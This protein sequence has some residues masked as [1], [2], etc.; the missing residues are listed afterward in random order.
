[1]K[2]VHLRRY[3]GDG[4]VPL[5][6]K[7]M[8]VAAAAY[9]VMPLDGIPDVVPL[10]GWL[11]DVG[12]VAA[13]LSFLVRDVRKHAAEAAPAALSAGSGVQRIEASSP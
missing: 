2:L 4:H 11:D 12:A 1:M 3:F 13:A 9:V 6:R 8:L 10:I 5:W 7:L